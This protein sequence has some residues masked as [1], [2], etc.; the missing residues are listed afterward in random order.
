MKK[1]VFGL[2]KNKDEAEKVIDQL[3]DLGF[4]H[5]NVSLLY[6][7]TPGSHELV[8]EHG[9]RTPEA[10]TTG[11]TT[12]FVIG[13]V[14]GWLAGIGLLA[15]PGVGPFVAAGPIMAALSGAAVGAAVGGIAG[16]LI[17]LGIPEVEARQY[18]AKLKE[19]NVL[20]SVHTDD[21]ST[22]E[23]ALNVLREAHAQDVASGG[24]PATPEIQT[25]VTSSF[26]THA[27]DIFQQRDQPTAASE[28]VTEPPLVKPEV[29]QP[30]KSGL[31][32]GEHDRIS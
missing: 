11:G 7:A 13:G 24:E 26:T 28:S 5:E 1:S 10:V 4:S 15:I 8:Q 16:A 18:E 19:G 9:T 25:R 30:A 2:L 14:L 12:G 31:E 29:I 3:K 27:E 6:P 23:K 22:A 20:I 32:P 21:D 17:G